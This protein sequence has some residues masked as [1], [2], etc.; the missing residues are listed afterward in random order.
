MT[1]SSRSRRRP[2]PGRPRPSR[3][4]Q[5]A[6]RSGQK[7]DPGDASRRRPG[8]HLLCQRVACSNASARF[9]GGRPR[10]EAAGERQRPGRPFTEGADDHHREV[11]R[12]QQAGARRGGGDDDASLAHRGVPSGGRGGCALRT[13]IRPPRDEPSAAA[14]RLRSGRPGA[15]PG[16]RAGPPARVRSSDAAAL[17]RP[18]SGRLP[19]RVR[20]PP[21]PARDPGRRRRPGTEHQGAVLEGAG[22][23]AD[24]DD[25]AAPPLRRDAAAPGRPH[26]REAWKVSRTPR[27]RGPWPSSTIP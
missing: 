18:A 5:S 25:G 14:E 24:R 26:R 16:S 1:A 23:R 8:G 11:T 19:A 13:G 4:R 21:P 2:V 9:G 6:R 15:S 22:D 27:L 17:Q 12:Y 20:A 10:R 7:G 3:R